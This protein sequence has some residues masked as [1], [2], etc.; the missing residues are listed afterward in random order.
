[1]MAECNGDVPVS[2]LNLAFLSYFFP[3]LQHSGTLRSA[4]FC[5]NLPRHLVNPV[6]FCSSDYEVSRQ[7]IV[8]HVV[9]SEHKDHPAWGEVYRSDWKLNRQTSRWSRTQS[10][11]PVLNFL[12]KRQLLRQVSEDLVID[13]V[14]KIRARG[15]DAIF[16]TYSPEIDIELGL[17]AAKTTGLPLMIDLR[18]PWSHMPTPPHRHYFDYLLAKEHEGKALRSASAIIVTT[19][20]HKSLLIREMALL[21][22]KIHVIRNGSQQANVGPASVSPYDSTEFN[23]AHIGTIGVA[24][25]RQRSHEFL[26]KTL[27]FDYDPL[28]TDFS[29]RSTQVFCNL[30]SEMANKSPGMLDRMRFTFVGVENVDRAIDSIPAEFRRYFR[31]V[32]RVSQAEA[33]VFATRADMLVL[34]Q[35]TQF[36]QGRPTHICIPAKLYDYMRTGNPI[37]AFLHQSEMSE[38]LKPYSASCISEDATAAVSF[39]ERVYSRWKAGQPLRGRVET[40]EDFDR[41]RQT[42]QLAALVRSV[43]EAS[44]T[45]VG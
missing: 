14:Q 1:M 2:A 20:A 23:I 13:V 22:S 6:I 39:V 34:N 16:S 24:A 4:A 15:C 27:G 8:G 35:V 41:Q 18:D 21:E 3:P 36:V 45:S 17:A 26:K 30:V 29:S 9:E 25:P 32:G 5:A 19:D 38:L 40:A 28:R 43:V 12:Q 7:N 42:G 33:D 37:L 10:R 44:R 11:V 31:F